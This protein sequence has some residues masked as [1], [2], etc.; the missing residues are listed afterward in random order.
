MRI[1]TLLWVILLSMTV[2]Q[3]ATAQSYPSRP[4]RLVLPF[5]PGS[6][7]DGIAR[8]IGEGLR[9]SLGQPVIVDNRP[10]ADGLIAAQHVA[11][12]LPDGYTVFVTTNSTHGVN[13]TLYKELPYDP[14]KDFLPVGGLM[15]ILQMM[16]VR[17]DFPATDVGSFV[18]EAR[19]RPKP[20]SFGSGNTS[21]RVA[22]ELLKSMAKIDMTHVPYR[23]APQALADLVSGQL[24]M[25]FSDPISAKSLFESEKIKVLAVA[26]KTRLHLFPNVPTMIESGYPDFLIVSWV[27]AF[28]PAK[29]DT[30]VVTR[31]NTEINVALARPEIIARIKSLGADAMPTSPEALGAF[32]TSEIAYWA[33][34]IELAGIERK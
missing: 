34:M 21:S 30:A 17:A 31:L 12:A 14:Q 9:K 18:E 22:G 11:Q 8:I 15:R 5:P 4:I 13:S 3:A 24:D 20:L 19:R 10:G 7:T 29:T 6:G 33:K 32:V 26:D 28:V 27:A 16:C 1:K 2:P 25:F 23:G